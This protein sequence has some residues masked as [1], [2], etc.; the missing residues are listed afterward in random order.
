[1]GPSDSHKAS[2]IWDL[3]E[4]QHGVV[5]YSQ[6]IA[7]GLSADAIRHRV[8]TARLHRVHPGV[9]AVG[10]PRLTQRGIWNA[11]VLSCGPGAVLSHESAASLLGLAPP[12]PGP[13][14]SIPRD[15]QLRRKGI[16]IHRVVFRRGD[17]GKF[18]SIAV[19]SPIRTLLD[20]ASIFPTRRLEAA[21]NEADRLGLIDPD[22]LR[23]EL[24]SRGGQRGVPALRRLLDVRTFRLTDSELERRFLRLVE[25]AGLPI[26]ET[27]VDLHGFKIDFLWRAEGLIVETDGLRYHRTAT[28][29]ERDRL[30]D[31]TH[32]AA[33][34]TTLRFTHS[35]VAREPG[36][37]AD[38]VGQIL[39]PKLRR[40]YAA[41]ARLRA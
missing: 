5:A 3:A 9:F 1:M 32:T 10:R 29:Q 2:Q 24:N 40:G 39:R 37:V 11:A 35:Q 4:R 12:G 36:R 15:R 26:P 14:V 30:R 21:V 38:L 41:R 8:Q 22:S 27:G 28:Q 23:S 20:L 6:L 33:G 34:L 17:T 18:D 7:A 13:V 16:R 19:T 31:Q 25:K